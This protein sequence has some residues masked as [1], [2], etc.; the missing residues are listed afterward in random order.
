MQ[1]L[2][3]FETF[4]HGSVD[5]GCLLLLPFYT[6]VDVAIAGLYL[7]NIFVNIVCLG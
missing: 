3:V 1:R 4:C 6:K 2:I 7:K 5:L